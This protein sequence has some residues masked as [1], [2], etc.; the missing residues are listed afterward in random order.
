MMIIAHRGGNRTF[1]ENS[2]E[3]VSHAFKIRADVAEIDSQLSKDRIPMV[4]HD[5]TLKRLFAIDHAVKD[6]N[7]TELLALQY[8]ERTT[9]HLTTLET[10]LQHRPNFPLLIHIKAKDAGILPTLEVIARIGATMQVIAGLMSL[11][12]LRL[13][14]HTNPNLR[15]LGFIP[16]PDAMTDFLAAGVEIIRL[17][18]A[19]VTPERIELIHRHG[20]PVWVMTGESKKN[21]GETTAER[22]LELQR[23]SV[24]GVLVNDIE[25]AV[26]TLKP[27]V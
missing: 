1:P 19:W 18:D 27:G 16:E 13:A 3:A 9:A 14:K 12:A 25:L 20:K 17:W 26:K 7:S 8:G 22:L 5:P 10:L 4:I 24:D 2:I 6:L 21:V 23:L 15:T 11:E